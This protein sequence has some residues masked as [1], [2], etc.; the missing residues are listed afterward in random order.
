MPDFPFGSLFELRAKTRE[1][2]VKSGD[3]PPRQRDG[4][5]TIFYDRVLQVRNTSPQTV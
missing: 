2:K 1:R 5:L 3:A 4:F